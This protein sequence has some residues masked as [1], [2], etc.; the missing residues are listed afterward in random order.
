MAVTFMTG[1]ESAAVSLDGGLVFTGPMAYSTVQARTG[2]R[3]LRCQKVSG[4]AATTQV[5]TLDGWLHFG[6]YLATLPTATVSIAIAGGTVNLYLTSSGKLRT[7]VGGADSTATLATGQWYWIGF[8]GVAGG[9]TGPWVQVNGVNDL[10]S[11]INPIGNLMAVGAGGT[12]ATALDAYYDDVIIDGAGFLSPSKVALLVPTADSA[13]GTGWTLGSGGT[14]GLWDAVNNEPPTA[15]ADTG[16]TAQIRNATSN[17]NVNYDATMTT[18]AAAGIATGDT[19]LAVQP[20]VST[21]A[22]VV[23]SAKA[24]TVGVASNPAI[25]NIALGAGGT[26][27]AFW[28]G[29]AGGT[30]PTGW[31]ASLGTLTTSPSVTLG[32]AP[33]MRVTQVTSSTRIAMVAFMGIYVAWTPSAVVTYVPRHGFVNHQNPGVL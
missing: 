14:T 17:A 24:G 18:Y 32:T 19:V 8:R 5:S 12:E 26:A 31:K 2:T 11:F 7:S 28:S 30:W 1:F 6:L 15:V 10:S 13:V 33:V 27:G 23:T 29:V 4:S 9:F 21:A 3:S 20:V 25:T 16:T 22:P